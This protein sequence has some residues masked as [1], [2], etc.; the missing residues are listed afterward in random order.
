MNDAQNATQVSELW[1]KADDGEIIGTEGEE[2]PLSQKLAGIIRLGWTKRRM[3]FSITAI[4]ILVSLLYAYSL[5]NIYSASTT[6]LPADNASPYTNMMAMLSSGSA[7][8]GLSSEALGINTPGELFIRILGSRT[9]QDSLIARFDLAHYYKSSL[10]QDAR[11]SLASDTSIDEDRKSGLISI[12][13]RSKNPVL[14]ANL[15]QGYVSELNRVVTDSSTSTARRE[16]IFLE[17]RLKDVKQDLDD[18]SKALSEFSAKSGVID[19]SSQ[20]KAMMDSGG[21]LQAELIDGRSQLAALRQY[22][23]ED[24]SKVRAVEARN[25]ELQREI[26]AMGGGHQE[27]DSH[28][29]SKSS[30]FPS[31]QELPALGRTYYD[32]ERQAKV[33][34]ALWEALTKQYEAA[35]VDEAKEM[36]TVR[37]LDAAEVPLHKSAPVR[38]RIMLIGTFLAFVAGCISVFATTFWAEMDPQDEPKKLL[39]E[40]FNGMM[41]FRRRA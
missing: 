3:I 13:V 36:P 30:A 9:V 17:G 39:S 19:V 15:A 12:T 41:F 11:G 22:Y 33:D 32:L 27:S 24:N 26:N 20:A 29:D 31:A 10:P 28:A 7:A 6:V 35:K 16:R 21:R 2:E 4:G 34:E 23:S 38:W 18:S 40:I 8:A 14:A 1:N 25:D 5:P 37:V